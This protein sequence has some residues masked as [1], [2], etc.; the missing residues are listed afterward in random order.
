MDNIRNIL[1]NS[2]YSSN[3]NQTSY[4]YSIGTE[5]THDTTREMYIELNA[6]TT[7]NVIQTIDNTS[8]TKA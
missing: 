4:Y 5:H 6:A 1:G 3:G 2:T 8:Y 7:H